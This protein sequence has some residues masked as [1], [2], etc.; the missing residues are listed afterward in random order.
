MH[1]EGSVINSVL[2]AGDDGQRMLP[3]GDV[4]VKRA[5]PSLEHPHSPEV[6]IHVVIVYH[7][8]MLLIVG[9]VLYLYELGQSNGL[10][11]PSGKNIT[12]W[13]VC[14]LSLFFKGILH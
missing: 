7:T 14:I 12:L 6:V 4:R 5:L 9:S 10:K 11:P 8:P 13:V 3:Q 1:L 2:D